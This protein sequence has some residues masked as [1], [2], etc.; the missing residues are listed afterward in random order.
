MAF[1]KYQVDFDENGDVQE[2]ILLPADPV[3]R[4][5]T[6]IVREETSHKA[7]RRAEDLYSLAE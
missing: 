2:P 5:R 1:N 3:S 4:K 6:I 7:K